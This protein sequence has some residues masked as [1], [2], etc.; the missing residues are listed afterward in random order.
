MASAHT[1]FE[2]TG[3]QFL[4]WALI[5]LK[6]LFTHKSWDILISQI[7]RC[8]CIIFSTRGLKNWM[9]NLWNI[10]H[11]LSEL[12]CMRGLYLHRYGKYI[13]VYI[14]QGDL[15]KDQDKRNAFYFI[16]SLP[17]N[18]NSEL[19]TFLRTRKHPQLLCGHRLAD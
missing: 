10:L 4:F 16:I 7:C 2:R 13:Y 12:L 1:K 17:L 11:K 14:P 18:R 15:C 19:T 8:T 9:E 6:F 3:K 5:S